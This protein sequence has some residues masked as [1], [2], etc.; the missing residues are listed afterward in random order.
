MNSCYC[1]AGSGRW[2]A[3]VAA[4][5]LFMVTGSVYA[6]IEEVVV[7][8]QKR[9]ESVQDVPISVSAFDMEA[10]ESRQIDT[11]SDLQ[12]NVPNVSYS[13]TNFSGNNFQIRGIGT[14]LTASSADSGVAMHINDVYL[15]SPR[16]FE[17]EYYDMQQVEILRGPQGTL[18]GR[19]AT[20][21]AVN[22]KTARPEIGELYGD[23]EA[24][25]GNFD[26]TKLKGAINVPLGERVAG[27]IAGIFVDREGY[28][29]DIVSGDDVDGRDQWSLRAS[30][31]FDIA[32]GTT[33]DIIGHTF[34]EDSN[35]SRSQKQLCNNDPSAILG[36][37]PD[38]FGFEPINAFATAGTLLSS[39]LILGNFGLFNFFNQGGGTADNPD[40]LRDVR[41]QYQPEYEAEEDFI[42][43]ELKHD[44]SESVT[45]TLIGAYQETEV[46]SRQDYNG[47]ASDTGAALIPPGFCATF[48]GV[49]SYFGTQDGGPV[50][51]STVVDGENSLGAIAG[52]DEVA[53]D[54]R[55]A[56]IDLSRALAEQWKRRVSIYH[57]FRWPSELYVC[58]LLHGVRISR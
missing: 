57:V 41:L 18:F 13:K 52:G 44:I 58:R 55:G 9:A 8:A 32:E 29:D 27:R 47:T 21:G 11:F 43:M 28:T 5:A 56:A 35:R 12:F 17:T 2:F 19:N 53:L 38:G 49:C 7:T 40:D 46:L 31:R 1:R 30:L 3:V 34:E 16:I 51:V 42:M 4:T 50:F 23:I 22:L 25:Y 24:Q 48:A 10:L 39:N 33:L 26:H 54:S 37:T 14:L 6:A 15:N 20:G 36:C 45:W